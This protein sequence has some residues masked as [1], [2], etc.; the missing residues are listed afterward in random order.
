MDVLV[1]VP[2]ISR[3]FNTGEL[4]M[5]RN[6]ITL[7][8]CTA[9]IALA[10]ASHAQDAPAPDAR[11]TWDVT[12]LYADRE[13]WDADR[14]T[15]LEQAGELAQLEG[16]LDDGPDAFLR[17]MQAYSDAMR[18]VMRVWTYAGLVADENLADPEGQALRQ[19][20]MALYSEISQAGAWI[21]PA[22][23]ALGEE[24]VWSYFEAEAE[25]APFRQMVR[26]TLRQGEHTLSDQTERALAALSPATSA[27]YTIYGQLANS[28]IPRPTIT[29]SD[30]TELLV[31]SAGYARGRALDN[32]E[33]RIAVFDAYW[34]S[35]QPFTGSVGAALNGHVQNA[36][37]QSRL[38]G[39]DNALSAALS[40]GNVPEE[41]YRTLVAE[42][43]AALPVLHR[44]F[45]LRA[46]LLG[47][48]DPAY[49]DIYPDMVAIDRDFGIED[50]IEL[51]RASLAPLGED[52]VAMYSDAVSQRWMHVYPQT[53]KTSGAYV[54]GAAYDVHP[55]VLLNH[56]DDYS[57]ATTFTHEWGHALHSVLAN[58][59]QP[60]ET[61]RYSIFTAE[62]AST[63]HEFLLQEHMLETA[64]TPQER[65]FYLG[66]ALELLRATFFRQ[67]MFSEF[68]LA[69]HET[70]ER[71][72]P[73]TGSA[74]TAIYADV[75]RRYHGHD[76]GVMQ[77]DD[78]YTHE[79]MFV[80]HF[81]MNFYVYQYATSLAAAA[82]FTDLILE[83]DEEALERY[84]GALRAGGS[85]DPYQILLDAGVD[86]ATPEPYRVL[87]ERMERTMDEMEAIL[88][89]MEN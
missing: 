87:V 54:S 61:A 40:G 29:L 35:W 31:N 59:A 81:Y 67:T 14:R 11:W 83:G 33:D 1:L 47:V 13:S 72:E 56:Q 3:S 82:Y 41:V 48:E 49:Y 62:V 78:L 71:G 64:Q 27:S 63:V 34:G 70:V 38:R 55:Y 18:T 42:T 25:L 9:V 4:A 74:I 39:Y 37:A 26:T 76:E 23:I 79:W 36:V 51:T 30:G 85:D 12:A 84:L 20:A 32:R 19:Q 50:S 28:E 10:P 57:S 46:R 22:I 24:T 80:P 53:G 75:V 17:V 6:I 88:A 5:R 65:L 89:E 45:A 43:N 15:G 73:L 21:D 16:T 8:A 69:I 2:I 7:L 77:V 68:E 52:Y 86:L 58:E 44:Y 60:F 66:N